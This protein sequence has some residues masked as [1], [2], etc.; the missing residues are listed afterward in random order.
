MA[1]R[2]RLRPPSSS[3]T[4][5]LGSYLLDV[6]RAVNQIPNVS[7]FSGTS[8]NL[9]NLTGTAGD[10]AINVGSASTDSRLWVKGGSVA[11]PTTTGWVTV[12]TGPA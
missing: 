4:G 9:S 1:G 8:P 2:D 12:R 6:W 10:L 3:I 7:Y 11:S 5:E